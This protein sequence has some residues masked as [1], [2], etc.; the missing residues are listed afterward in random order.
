M[1]AK[2]RIGELEA[3]HRRLREENQTQQHQLQARMQRVHELEGQLSRDSHNSSKPPG[4]D[5][6]RRLPKSLRKRSGKK[7]GGQPEHKGH[8]LA[9]VATPDQVIALHPA[10]CVQWHVSLEEV[11]AQQDERRQVQD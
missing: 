8:T 2:E 1:G 11:P 10:T 6:L 5:G 3:E 9:L 7:P 4:S